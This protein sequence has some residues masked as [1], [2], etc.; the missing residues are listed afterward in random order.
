MNESI[1]ADVLVDLLLDDIMEGSALLEFNPSRD[2]A[3]KFTSKGAGEAYAHGV[4]A[5]G[6]VAGIAAK[7]KGADRAGVRAAIKAGMDQHVRTVQYTRSFLS[8]VYGPGA[9]KDVTNV[10]AVSS[11]KTQLRMVQMQRSYM[12]KTVR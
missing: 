9:A 5:A 8:N 6:R 2:A 10:M 1:A 11:P 3:G 4:M 12:K 7:T